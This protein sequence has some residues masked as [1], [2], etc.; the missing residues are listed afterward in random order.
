M[1]SGELVVTT[2]SGQQTLK[3]LNGQFVT[4]GYFE[5]T[6]TRLVRGRFFSE[7]DDNSS[8]QAVVVDEAFCAAY[9]KGVDPL[10]STVTFGT[11][12][13]PIIGVVGNLRQATERQREQAGRMDIPGLAYLPFQWNTRAPAW[14]FLV[15]R[16]SENPAVCD[17]RNRARTPGRRSAR[18]P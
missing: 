7:A 2:P 9:L 11:K 15:V 6:G 12:P 5:A 14:S 8:P 18:L 4:S 10:A 3:R 17:C 1:L 13:M 16:A